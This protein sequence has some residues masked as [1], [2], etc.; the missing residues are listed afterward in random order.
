[1]GP[2]LFTQEKKKG[3]Q[4]KPNKHILWVWEIIVDLLVKDV[5]DHIEEIPACNSNEFVI[6]YKS[7]DALINIFEKNEMVSVV[8]SPH[9][10]EE[11]SNQRWVLLQESN[12]CLTE[13]SFG[14]K[15]K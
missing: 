4:A 1:M 6:Y 11:A 15:I 12:F 10:E 9:E 7:S 5:E 8:C 3:Q 13:I 2:T 14:E